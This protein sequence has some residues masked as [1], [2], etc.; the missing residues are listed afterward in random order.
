MVV[1]GNDNV[2]KENI[3]VLNNKDSKPPLF[4]SNATI[5]TV[6]NNDIINDIFKSYKYNKKCNKIHKKSIKLR[7]FSTI[8]FGSLASINKRK[9]L[10]L[11]KKL[12]KV[13]QW[14]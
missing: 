14:Q 4:D 9:K 10:I 13:Y 11:R 2:I 12:M 7:K 8:H 1:E 3:K 6:N 5:S